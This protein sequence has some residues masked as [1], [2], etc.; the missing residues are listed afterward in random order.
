MYIKSH[1]KELIAE[2]FVDDVIVAGGIADKENYYCNSDDVSNIFIENNDLVLSILDNTLKVISVKE[3][4][5]KVK[6]IECN[7]SIYDCYI[8]LI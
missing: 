1:L 5:T 4:F 7:D 8:K 2:S 6:F 3:D